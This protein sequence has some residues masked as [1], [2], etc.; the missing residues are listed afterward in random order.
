[1][2][3]KLGITLAYARSKGFS[4]AIALAASMVALVISM[5]VAWLAL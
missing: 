4:A 1:M 5:V 2:T 3:V